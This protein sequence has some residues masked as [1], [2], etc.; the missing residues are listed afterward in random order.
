MNLDDEKKGRKFMPKPLT[1]LLTVEQMAEATGWKESTVRQK[2][3]LRQ[4]SYVKLGRSIRFK[5]EV[6]DKLI[7]DATVPALKKR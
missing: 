6:L 1:K 3:W 7:D 2:V 4:L 5:Q